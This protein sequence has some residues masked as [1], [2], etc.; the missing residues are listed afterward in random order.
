MLESPFLYCLPDL[1]HQVVEKENIMNCCVL[2]GHLVACPKLPVK[3]CSG[4]SLTDRTAAVF[5]QL[6]HIALIHS[7]SDVYS[8]FL[9]PNS[10]VPRFPGGNDAVK[11]IY[12]E[13]HSLENVSRIANAQKVSRMAFG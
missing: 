2:S 1:K 8:P 9:C 12:A 11:S 4:Q 5:V 7:F 3:L 6:S 13:F 10:S